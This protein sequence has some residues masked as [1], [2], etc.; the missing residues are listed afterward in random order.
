M[1]FE[2]KLTDVKQKL[3]QY[4][5]EGWLLYD[6]RRSNPLAC[7]F[8]EI[9]PEANLTR[10]FFYWI[11]LEGQPIKVVSVIEQH[12][13][14]HL[15]G[16]IQAYSSWQGLESILA[17]LLENVTKVAMEYSPR[18]A[19]P[20]VSKVDG[21]TLEMIRSFGVQVA[22]SANI[23]QNYTSIWSEFQLQTH[24]HALTV[25]EKG[26]ELAWEMICSHLQAK[27]KLTEYD[28]QQFLLKYIH[29]HACEC[30][31]P[32]ICAVNAHSAN[33]H[34]SPDSKQAS[35]IQPEDFILID[36]W[37]KQTHPEAVYADITQVGVAAAGATER[38][39]KI[40]D[41]VKAARDTATE[42]VRERVENR[43]PVFGWE[44]DQACRSVIEDAGFSRYFIH[45]TGHN[46]GTED[47]G[48]GA[49]LDDLETHDQRLLLPGT[50]F[51]I[52]PG[53]YL[54]QEFGVRLEYDVYIHPNHKVEVTGNVQNALI[55]L[56]E[57]K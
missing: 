45:R 32:P 3:A 41:I 29:E 50:C 36:L 43:I 42:F 13:L 22:S 49:H 25:L 5:L 6:F 8:L 4:R 15:P 7:Q 37:C 54:P 28:V 55:C 17:S 46:I 44:A 34:Y 20:S 51:S 56:G 26:V 24:R 57:C 27:Q 53:I 9:P 35:E 47:H 12:L 40:F 33:P 30:S 21:G 16:K 38:Q 10:R 52:E 23:L 18:N 2:K 31:D 1:S 19:I 14:D 11:P 48:P 39:Q